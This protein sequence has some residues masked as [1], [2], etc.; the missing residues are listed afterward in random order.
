MTSPSYLAEPRESRI[1]P[2]DRR[3]RLWYSQIGPSWSSLTGTT[4]DPDDA[5]DRL[6]DHAAHALRARRE[7]SHEERAGPVGGGETPPSHREQDPQ[8]PGPP[9]SP[10]GPSWRPRRLH[11]QPE[12]RRHY[13]GHGDQCP[14]G[15]HRRHRLLRARERLWHRELVHREEQLDENQPGRVR[16][17]GP[18]DARRNDASPSRHGCRAGRVEGRV[19]ARDR[20]EGI[21]LMADNNRSIEKL[22]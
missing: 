11:P 6:R 13:D 4:Y 21:I 17:P 1:W 3:S 16:R 12:A 18:R 19:P 10:G 15:S 7:A 9:R 2:L 22:A 5:A 20:S 8:A 14:R